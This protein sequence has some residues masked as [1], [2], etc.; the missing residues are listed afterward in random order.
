MSAIWTQLSTNRR[1][2]YA[3]VA[4]MLAGSLLFGYL[5]FSGNAHAFLDLSSPPRLDY[6]G[7]ALVL[8]GFNHVL[9]ALIWHLYARDV[10]QERDVLKD[11]LRYSLTA[12]TRSLPGAF[13]WSVASR[14]LLYQQ[15]GRPGFATL[16]TG[17]ELAL[18]TISG[19]A[20]ALVLL[21]WPWGV[22][23]AVAI[24]VL[25]LLPGTEA[26]W[27]RLAGYRWFSQRWPQVGAA[28]RD[29]SRLS[30]RTLLI[31]LAAYTLVWVLGGL[32][33]EALILAIGASL[34]PRLPLYGIWVATSLVGTV[35]SVLL[36]GIGA[37]RELTLAGLLAPLLSLPV[38][39]VVSLLSRA[40]L[41]LGS[42]LWGALTALVC[43]LAT[44]RRSD[45]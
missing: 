15:D 17:A 35:G 14:V 39:T 19:A 11:V 16:A 36:G 34:P 25:P 12:L 8:V 32:F 3:I 10:H 20:L 33:L 2:R 9:Q 29:V 21:G 42:W 31:S 45:P 4:A 18:Q 28:F 40:V 1:L 24:L 23:P 43:Q 6:L 13:Y 27:H 41:V 44:R 7:L 38:A 22:I 26:M 30:R 37:V 5:A